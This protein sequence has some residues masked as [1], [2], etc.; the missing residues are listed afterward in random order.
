MTD[1]QKIEYLKKIN[2]DTESQISKKE[3][4]IIERI[5]LNGLQFLGI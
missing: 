5:N 1:R 2:D 3:L 4:E